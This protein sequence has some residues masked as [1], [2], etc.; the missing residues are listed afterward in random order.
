[1]MSTHVCR[2]LTPHKVLQHHEWIKIGDVTRL[3]ANEPRK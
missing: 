3:T 2:K 1:M